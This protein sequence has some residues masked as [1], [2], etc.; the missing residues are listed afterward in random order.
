MSV[1]RQICRRVN[2]VIGPSQDGGGVETARALADYLDTVAD[3]LHNGQGISGPA[4][5]R[6]IQAARNARSRFEGKF[7]TPRQAE[8]QPA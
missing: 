2:S 5:E 7:L 6:M 8:A 4:A 3:D 1:V